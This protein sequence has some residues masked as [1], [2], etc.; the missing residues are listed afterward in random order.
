MERIGFLENKIK[1]ENEEHRANNQR[2][3]D[4]ISSSKDFFKNIF[5]GKDSAT[6]DALDTTV[7]L[8]T[9]DG[10]NLDTTIG[11]LPESSKQQAQVHQN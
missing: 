7:D 9:T 5:D 1:A 11:T 3:M 10:T 4:I 6:S 2:L 8:N